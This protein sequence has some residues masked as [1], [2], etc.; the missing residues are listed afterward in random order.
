MQAVTYT[1]YG[2]PDVLRLEEVPKPTPGKNDVLIRVHAAEATKSDCELRSFRFPVKWFWL[3]LRIGFGVLK[4][5][6]RILGGYFAGAVEAVGKNVSRFRKGDPVFGC[7][8]LRLGAYGEYM[9]LPADVTI[10][11]KPRNMSFEEAAAVPLGGLNALHFLRKANIRKG[12]KVL[13][14]GAG[15]SIGTFG[16]QIAKAMGA[17]VTAVDSGIKEEMLRRIGADHFFDYTRENVVR[18]GRT[19]DVILNLVVKSAYSEFIKALNP[20]GRYLL[21]NPRVADMFKGVVT[22]RFTD[23]KVFFALAGETETE[24]STLKEMI[25]K[26]RLQAVID[27]AYPMSRAA[28]AHQRVETEQRLGIVVISMGNTGHKFLDSHRELT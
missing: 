4:P 23:K 16:V 13:I 27:K 15:G 10:V 11:P 5:R 21:S 20:G 25:E 22:S 24:L 7:A 17:E 6:R 3:P 2:P 1:Q 18:I 8:G 9:R 12:E 14:N 19:W 28:E 26:G